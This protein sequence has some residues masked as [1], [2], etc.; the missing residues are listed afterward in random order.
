M[1]GAREDTDADSHCKG[2]V[3]KRKRPPSRLSIKQEQVRE[4][5]RVIVKEILRDSILGEVW[6]I[7]S[8]AEDDGVHS[9]EEAACMDQED[10]G[11]GDEALKSPAGSDPTGQP[12][13]CNLSCRCYRPVTCDVPV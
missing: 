3:W 10:I 2:M 6:K 13:S 5:S 7:G 4:C 12:G 9:G 1:S 8:K 11:D